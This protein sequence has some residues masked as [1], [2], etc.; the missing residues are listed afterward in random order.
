MVDPFMTAKQRVVASVLSS[1][2]GMI[3][4]PILMRTWAPAWAALL[5]LIG[6][7]SFTVAAWI[8]LLR[9]DRNIEQVWSSAVGVA[10]GLLPVSAT[11]W[12]NGGRSYWIAAVLVMV[13]IATEICSLPYIKIE[14]WRV[15]VVTSGSMV[16][17]AGYFEIGIL[18]F[19]MAP[20]LYSIISSANRMRTTKNALEDARI[21][22][23]AK[24]AEAER[25]AHRDELTGLLNRRGIAGELDRISGLPYTILMVDGDRFKAINDS[26]GYAA[27]DQVIQ[28]IARVLDRRLGA[29]WTVGRHGGDEFV[30]LAPGSHQ[31]DLAICAPVTCKVSQYGTISSLTIGLSGGHLV[32][33]GGVH[34]ETDM[35]KAS[36]TMR[37]AKRAGLAL[38]TFD[39]AL[40]DQFDRML[41][42]STPSGHEMRTS[43]LTAHF[44]IVVDNDERIVGFEALSRWQRSDGTLVPPADFLPVLADNGQMPILN[45]VMLTQGIEFAARFN[46]HERPPFVAVNIGS[47][48]LASSDLAS[49]VSTLLTR[50]RVAAHRLMI[51][52]TETERLGHAATW[53]AAAAELRSMGVQLA[54]DDFGSGYSN[55]ERLNQLPISHLKFD[56][57]LTTAADGPLGQIAR[58]VVDFAHHTGIGIIAEG[59]ENEQELAAMRAI[60]VRLFQGY[61]FGRPT[62]GDAVAALVNMAT[63][64]NATADTSLRK[65]GA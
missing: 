46:D 26:H 21:S 40:S 25:L 55:I 61:Y 56:R 9:T 39:E 22:A 10:F 62:N 31:L 8:V 54:I 28:Q 47:S 37:A 20:V 27:G 38:L 63:T 11:V 59:I 57:S 35:S 58:G 12:D 41:E 7:A 5:W 19:A 16:V 29:P 51:E 14:E 60:G 15:G 64:A 13:A 43:S 65:L 34:S 48:S 49:L 53:E 32:S 52:I 18:S 23:D 3:G 2:P 36:Y 33:S 50:H 4:I 30:A 42:I 44:Q 45:E 24:T 17:A 1:V 6:Y